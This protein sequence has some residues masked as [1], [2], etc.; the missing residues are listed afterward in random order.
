MI[1]ASEVGLGQG[2]TV[3][4]PG[5]PG[6]AVRALGPLVLVGDGIAR[7][8]VSAA[9]GG[10]RQVG[11]DGRTCRGDGDAVWGARSAVANDNLVALG[12]AALQGAIGRARSRLPVIASGEVG[13][14]ERCA[15][16]APVSPGCPVIALGPLVLVGYGVAGVRIGAPGS[17]R[18]QVI[19]DLRVCRRNRDRGGDSRRR[20]GND[21]RRALD[22][23]ALQRPVGG[24]CPRLPLV[25][26]SQVCLGERCAVVAPVAPGG[27]IGAL[28]PLVLIGH[29]VAGVE[30]GAARSGG[31]QIIGYG[32]IGGS[33]GHVRGGAWRA[34]AHDDFSAF[35]PGPGHHRIPG[36]GSRFPMIALRQVRLGKRLAVIAPVAPGDP[37]GALGPLVLVGHVPALRVRGPGRGSGQIITDRRIR[38]GDRHGL[39]GVGLGIPDQDIVALDPVTVQHPRGDAR[40]GLPQVSHGQVGVIERLTIVAP[41]VPV[42]AIG[43]LRPLAFDGRVVGRGIVRKRHGGVKIVQ[44]GREQRVD[45]CGS[46]IEGRY[47]G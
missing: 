3:I 6:C 18:D 1:A 42:D 32:R 45:V 10:R 13:L 27:A 2:L 22:P 4:S 29:H 9:R 40:S 28:G 37:I 43:A 11:G 35:G 16:V 5:V 12:P 31:G 20:P 15:V 19:A 47:V 30:V 7:I 44:N 26:L 8:R 38:R 46:H 34:V 41:G 17:R 14:G 39:R 36:P 21:H 24:S 23:V 25:A 33:D